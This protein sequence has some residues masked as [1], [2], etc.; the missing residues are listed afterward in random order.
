MAKKKKRKEDKKS[1]SNFKVEIVG[2]LLVLASIIGFVPYNGF[3]GNLIKA[4]AIFL[5]G[6]WYW[7]F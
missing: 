6:A 5:F 1:S 4:F 3:V 7:I 2:I